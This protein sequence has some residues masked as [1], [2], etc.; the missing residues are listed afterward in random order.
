VGKKVGLCDGA[1]ENGMSSS[2]LKGGQFDY[3][4]NQF[5]EKYSFYHRVK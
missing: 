5:L 2:A 1:V 4:D 3:H